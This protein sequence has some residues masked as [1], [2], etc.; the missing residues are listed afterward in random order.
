MAKKA[1]ATLTLKIVTKGKEALTGIKDKFSDL[2]SAV[3]TGAKIIGTSLL[4]FGT[5]ITALANKSSKFDQVKKSFEN[6]A[7]SQ[8]QNADQV[9]AKMKQLSQGMISEMDL[10]TAANSAALLGLPLDQ[11]DKMLKIAQSASEATGETM[12]FMLNSIVTGLGRQS[13]LILDNLGIIVDTEK[14]YDKFAKTLG[15]TVSQ[16]TEA[17]KKQAFINETMAVGMA[18]A[19]NLAG[20]TDNTTKKFSRF[21]AG[22]ED[23]TVALGQRVTPATDKLWDGMN[24]LLN[25]AIKFLQSNALSDVFD[26]ASISLT[27]MTGFLLKAKIGFSSLVEAGSLLKAKITF[28][29][30]DAETARKN[31]AQ[32]EKDYLNISTVTTEEI[33]KIRTKA[34]IRY[35]GIVTD[36][37]KDREAELRT[38]AENSKKKEIE[39]RLE[40]EK[41][42]ADEQAL[43]EEKKQENLNEIVKT[44][45]DEYI[46]FKRERDDRLDQEATQKAEEQAQKTLERNQAMSNELT[47]FMSGGIQNVAQN[48]VASFT[49]TFLPGFGGAAGQAFAILSQ[50][51]DQFLETL[52]QLFSTD[53][54]HNVV[55]NIPIFFE[56]LVD[57]MPELI[58]ELI[59]TIIANSPQIVMALSKAMNDPKFWEA[60]ALAF[61]NGI[62]NGMRA[63]VNDMSDSIKE[64]IQN[65]A[66][67]IGT[68][69]VGG[70]GGGLTNVV[71]SFTGGG[72][73]KL[74]KV[75][76]F[77][78]GGFVPVQ[79]FA[80]GGTVD[81][82]PAM[83][84]PGEFVVNPESTKN[85]L[86]AL[87]NINSGGSGGGNSIVINVNGGLMGDESQAREFARVIDE[88]LLKLRRENESLSF[89]SAIF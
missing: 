23:L 87:Q 21:K 8:G 40:Q 7:A 30:E 53:F 81:T 39:T 85:N 45:H 78:E 19:D 47:A 63:S 65:A 28:N 52:N 64:A 18:N 36:E 32:L 74:K 3:V 35:S 48:A 9:L 43:I 5:A 41:A 59:G 80:N 15:K 75:F 62:A 25:I 42:A 69:A 22:L 12:D 54:I 51:T 77:A 76:G 6:L 71:D 17:E 1:E 31:L 70:S 20:S 44:K 38:I 29:D 67:G 68:A 10:M 11:F 27:K 24:D 14:A 34:E 58:E 66:K 49:E 37:Q 73:S 57:K 79:K 88:E 13:K 33:A 50:D 82:V 86:S 72:A 46:Q 84:S 4:A 61:A 56:T 83:L 16:L 89:D 55:K 2:S 26:F 60:I